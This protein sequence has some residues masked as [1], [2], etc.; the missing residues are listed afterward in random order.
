MGIRTLG[1]GGKT[2][3][4]THTMDI[5]VS[6]MCSWGTHTYMGKRVHKH[7]TRIYREG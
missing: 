6:C 4:H 7:S 5:E 2:S 1:R 3:S